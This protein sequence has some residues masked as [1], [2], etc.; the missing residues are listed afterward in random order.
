MGGEIHQPH[1][2]TQQIHEILYDNINK[3]LYGTPGKM[4]NSLPS[5][6]WKISPNELMHKKYLSNI[7]Y[8]LSLLQHALLL[9]HPELSTQPRDEILKSIANIKS[10]K[11]FFIH[12]NAAFN[13][14]DQRENNLYFGQNYIE[15]QFADNKSY[16]NLREIYSDYLD[17]IQQARNYLSK[18]SAI[19]RNS[20]V[21]DE[22]VKHTRKSRQVSNN[23]NDS[24][25][26]GENVSENASQ[27]IISGKHNVVSNATTEL[28]PITR[29][30]NS[31]MKTA[32]SLTPNMESITNAKTG[33][34]TCPAHSARTRIIRAIKY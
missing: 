17:T 3:H 20:G 25:G 14:K 16:N 6:V 15:K 13:N 32:L 4:I 18:S 26:F 23:N 1:N 27:N 9:Q 5:K 10:G 24:F 2:K 33:K 31:N 11:G 34:K 8:N 30:F 22:N 28:M 21:F 29:N 12:D 19:L 7:H